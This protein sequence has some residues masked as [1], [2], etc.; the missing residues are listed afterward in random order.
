MALSGHRSETSIRNYT[1]QTSFST[2]RKMSE[3]ISKSLNNNKQMA[4]V[5]DSGS[6]KSTDSDN[7]S[8][9]DPRIGGSSIGQLLDNPGPVA[10]QTASTPF[11][12]DQLRAIQHTVQA[13]ITDS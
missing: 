2:K 7:E 6:S 10:T 8:F 11:T 13:S 12:G 1:V 9:V 5:D 4:L 3:T